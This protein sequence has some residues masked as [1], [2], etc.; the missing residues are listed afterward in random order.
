MTD[1][2]TAPL[3]YEEL[4]DQQENVEEI[5]EGVFVG[6]DYDSIYAAIARKSMRRAELI[7][8]NP[9]IAKALK[10]IM[11]GLE[12]WAS[13]HGCKPEHLDVYAKMTG[14]GQIVVSVRRG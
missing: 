12:I 7:D 14:D 5:V 1:L 10:K 8:K 2:D 13:E 9:T 11:I 3:D 6:G 4:V